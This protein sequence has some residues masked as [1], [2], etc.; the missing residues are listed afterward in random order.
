M[1]YQKEFDQID[2]LCKEVGSKVK[3]LKK[4]LSIQVFINE[5]KNENLGIKL[6]NLYVKVWVGG[7]MLGSPSVVVSENY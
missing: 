7:V 5:E 6:S 3:D 4:A 2:R 1:R